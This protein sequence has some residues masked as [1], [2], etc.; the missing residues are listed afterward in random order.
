MYQIEVK[1]DGKYTFRRLSRLARIGRKSADKEISYHQKGFIPSIQ[2]RTVRGVGLLK[3]MKMNHHAF[4]YAL[5]LSNPALPNY[6]Y[7]EEVEKK[8]GIS[9]SP[10]FDDTSSSHTLDAL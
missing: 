5:Y 7:C 8:F 3:R 1:M 10:S 9:L 2:K 4:I 6:G